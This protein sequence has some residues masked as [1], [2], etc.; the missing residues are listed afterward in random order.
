MPCSVDKGRAVGVVY[1]DFSK[2]FNTV[3]CRPVVTLLVRYE[4]DRWSIKYGE[5]ERERYG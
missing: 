1:F 2:A 3:S 5:R 4:P